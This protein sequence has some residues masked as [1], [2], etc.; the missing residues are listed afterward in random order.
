LLDRVGYYFPFEPGSQESL[1]RDAV[2]V[3]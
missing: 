2:S 1:W 3:F